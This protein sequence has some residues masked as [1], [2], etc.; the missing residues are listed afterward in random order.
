MDH[1]IH[2]FTLGDKSMGTPIRDKLKNWGNRADVMQERVVVKVWFVGSGGRKE[3]RQNATRLTGGFASLRQHERLKV[4][5]RCEIE[6][7]RPPSVFPFEDVV[8]YSMELEDRYEVVFA[9]RDSGELDRIYEDTN[10]LGDVLTAPQEA[11]KL[12]LMELE[13]LE[14]PLPPAS[15][16]LFDLPKGINP[17]TGKPLDDTSTKPVDKPMSGN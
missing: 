5:R 16:S 14:K 2:L 3:A 9:P 7:T 15:A 17:F 1:V 4:L 13:A 12:Q 10:L 11:P 8:C 6:G